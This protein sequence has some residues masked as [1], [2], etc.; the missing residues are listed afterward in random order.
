V[1]LNEGPLKVRN[2]KEG[3]DG[4]VLIEVGRGHQGKGEVAK[5]NL[6]VGRRGVMF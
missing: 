6:I 3:E 5:I 4:E 1:G 2:I